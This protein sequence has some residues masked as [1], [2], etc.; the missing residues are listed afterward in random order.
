MP[1]DTVGAPLVVRTVVSE[2]GTPFKLIVPLNLPT[3]EQ[4][5]VL[6]KAYTEHVKHP[7]GHW[8]GAAEA[9]VPADVADLVAEAMD[10]MGSIVD[11]RQT[12]PDGTVK[13]T[14]AGY[15]AHGF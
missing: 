10:F 5:E 15:W 1:T 14:S 2:E 11:D 12:L 7:E 6:R 13:L 8:K 9:T 3:E 4:A